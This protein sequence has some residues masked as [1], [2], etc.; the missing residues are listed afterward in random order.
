MNINSPTYT[1]LQDFI[2]SDQI[3]KDKALKLISLIIKLETEPSFGH[4][5]LF[6]MTRPRGFGLSLVSSA[7]DRIIKKDHEVLHKIENEGILHEIPKRHTLFLDFK[8]FNA[9]NVKEFKKSLI[10]ILQELFWFHHIESQFNPYITP[11]VF[12]SNLID[13]L[14]KRHQEPLVIFIDNY[15]IPLLRAAMMKTQS[16]IIEC[17]C[18]YHDMLNILE[19]CS[20]A[21][22]KWGLLTGHTKFHLASEL[23]EGLPLVLDL[24]SDPAFESMFGFTKDELKLIFEKPIEKICQAK[25][26]DADTYVDSLEKCY[27]GFAFSDNLV[28]VMCPACISHVMNNNGLLLPYSA[29]GS[30]TFLRYALK[31]KLDRALDLEWLFNK[32]GQDPLYSNSIDHTLQG[33]QI[34]TLLI[35]LGFAVRTKVLLNQD[36]AY[37]SWRY[38]FECPNLD[39]K[40][41]FEI[42]SGKAPKSEI[43][44]PLDVSQDPTAYS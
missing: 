36:E 24:S 30:Y 27:G 10:D 18:L 17:T 26:I 29:T 5:N 8:R 15:D 35:Q 20:N 33:K 1:S 32:D 41:T 40:K 14:Y 39:M 4:T 3:Y 44:S 12:F 2:I 37:T 31:Q 25:Q 23:S 21:K 16:E 11:K 34:G 6:L 13:A 19:K 9:S 43:T 42:I 38:R 28:K 22:V 7:I